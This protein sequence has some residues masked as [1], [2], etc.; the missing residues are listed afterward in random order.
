MP[1]LNPFHEI[2]IESANDLMA[3]REVAEKARPIPF[4]EQ[5]VSMETWRRRYQQAT[6]QMRQE[7]MKGLGTDRPAQMRELYKRMRPRVKGP[8]PF[9]GE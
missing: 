5:K 9:G 2:A 7:M 3:M 8:T 6:P 1:K 4:G